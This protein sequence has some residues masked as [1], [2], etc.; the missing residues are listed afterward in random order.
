MQNTMVGSAL[1]AVNYS[2]NSKLSFSGPITGQSLGNAALVRMGIG[3]GADNGCGWIATY[4]A[5]YLLGT[6][7]P[8]A[9]I[10][11]YMDTNGGANIGGV[12]GVNPYAVYQYLDLMGYNT[13]ITF[14][15]AGLDKTI[16]NSKSQMGI[17]MYGFTNSNGNFNIHY[18][19]VDYKNG[20]YVFYN[21]YQNDPS[22]RPVNS[23]DLYVKDNKD[24]PIALITINGK[25]T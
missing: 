23:L 2:Y 5:L 15:P 25:A 16:A 7:V 14:Y 19:I 13:N 24:T 10:V 11:Q 18:V 22:T 8:P 20:Q 4:N 6:P 1:A 9:N 17:L 21:L 3:T 12:F